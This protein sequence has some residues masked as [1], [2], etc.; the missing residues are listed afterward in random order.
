MKLFAYTI[1]SARVDTA[2]RRAIL[3]KIF[4]KGGCIVMTL[5]LFIGLMERSSK[6]AFTLKL[7][8]SAMV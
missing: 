6:W 1:N 7:I 2:T 4:L 8:I 3:A 5:A